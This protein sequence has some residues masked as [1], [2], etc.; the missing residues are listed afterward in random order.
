MKA[1]GQGCDCLHIL[2]RRLWCRSFAALMTTGCLLTL[3]C[4][5]GPRKP[6]VPVSSVV[7]SPPA[8]SLL[9]AATIQLAAV[10]LD[11]A[12]NTLVGRTV[13]WS[14]S[15]PAVATV[16]ATGL[17]T[18]VSAGIAIIT[19]SSE[20]KSGS[21][22]VVVV[23][24]TTTSITDIHGFLDHCPTNDPA[25]ARIV[26]D[27][28]I[29]LDGQLITAATTCTEP[30][31]TLPIAQFTDRLVAY[32]ILRT[33]YYMDTDTRGRLPWTP[34]GLYTWMAS[35]I[36]GVNLKSA[37][38]LFFCCELINGKKYI[39]TSIQDA[40]QREF[41]RTWLGIS[42][43]LGFYAH[44]IRHANP[45]APGH[46]TGCPA[47]PLPTDPAG[48]DAAYDLNNLGSYG[49][50]YWLESSWATGALNIGIGCAP[51]GIPQQ[52]AEWNRNSANS[53]RGRFVT[54]VPP[55]V[56]ANPPYGGPCPP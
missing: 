56:V 45:G 37:P 47:F 30:I 54:N 7:V 43:S 11:A 14:S 46:V 32:Q 18:G 16:S 6:T 2:L 17:V 39:A 55:V 10:T 35:N 36:G 21:S 29:R 5:G 23:T 20:G 4:G 27:F 50:Q 13:T 24:L 22:Q 41:K 19:A 26:A 12:G 15:N 9:V 3:A 28:D 1:V 33:A 48:C 34:I 49:V 42:G 44:E 8:P 51:G 52:Y 40:T 53:F 25:Y 31:A 38:G